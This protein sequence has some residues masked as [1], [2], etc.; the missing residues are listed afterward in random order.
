MDGGDGGGSG[1]GAEENQVLFTDEVPVMMVVAML[2]CVR[3]V[4]FNFYKS[5]R[6][7]RD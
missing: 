1:G 5:K 6:R 4:E 3:R 2:D 7:H